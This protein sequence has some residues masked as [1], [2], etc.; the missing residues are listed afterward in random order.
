MNKLPNFWPTSSWKKKAIR[1]T[2]SHPEF[3]S[4]KGQTVY[5]FDADLEFSENQ[6]EFLF[7]A[8][9]HLLALHTLGV[10]SFS[11]SNAT[12]IAK[13]S[14]IEF[15]IQTAE[16]L[17]ILQEIYLK[18]CYN[19]SLPQNVV[20]VDVGMNVG[21]ASLFFA[22]KNSVKHV[23]GYEPFAPTFNQCLS[24]LNRNQGLSEKISPHQF[25]LGSREETL[26]LEY[27]VKRKGQMSVPVKLFDEQPTGLPYEEIK[28]VPIIQVLNQVSTKHPD[29]SIVCKID[30]EGG[31][32]E[33]FDVFAEHGI[34]DSI[35]LIILEWHKYGP[36]PLLKIL[37]KNDFISVAT[38]NSGRRSGM[39]YAFRQ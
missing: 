26:R 37:D 36:E 34:P 14:E 7:D 1:L 11:I 6:F 31:E 24:N 4:L 18:N 23:Y 3:I 27:D 39:I 32:Y 28:L 17:F 16:E 10:S 20:V 15:E 8:F 5:L 35:T 13:V 12:V 22:S 19:F 25:G 38:S 2:A 29:L 30:C 21:L 33:L 9:D